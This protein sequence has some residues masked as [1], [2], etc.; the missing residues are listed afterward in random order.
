MD[1]IQEYDMVHSRPVKL[2]LDT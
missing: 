2:P 1:L